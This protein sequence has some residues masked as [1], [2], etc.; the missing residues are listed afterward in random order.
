MGLLKNIINF[1]ELF[2]IIKNKWEG[3]S[4]ND[5]P[6]RTYIQSLSGYKDPILWQIPCD[7]I[8][9]DVVV[10]GSREA[11]YSPSDK[12]DID[13]N[14]YQLVYTFLGLEKKHFPLNYTA[15]KNTILT[16]VPST[17]LYRQIVVDIHYK[18]LTKKGE[19]Q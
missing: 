2:A 7:C 19:T 16:I 13:V 9:T 12:I 4:G 5:E 1:D 14:Q 18:Q 11:N 8:I 15:Y 10:Y 3:A 17:R 6:P